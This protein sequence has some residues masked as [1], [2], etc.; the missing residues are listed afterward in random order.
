MHESRK[1]KENRVSVCCRTASNST[2]HLL[3]VAVNLQQCLE[4]DLQIYVKKIHLLYFR[5]VEH[6]QRTSKFANLL[7]RFKGD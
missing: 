4:G 7:R 6:L 1:I 5:T 2:N 3:K